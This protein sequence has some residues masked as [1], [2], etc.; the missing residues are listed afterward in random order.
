MKI[1]LYSITY[2]GVWYRGE[3]LDVFQLVHLAKEQGWDGLE[4]DAERPHAAP[5]D[6]AA[7]DRKRLRDL[8]G[9]A[10]IELCAVSPNCDLSSPVPGQR[11]AM[12]CYVRE[13]IRLAR[14]LGAPI[15]KIFAAWRGITLH[16]GMATYDDTYGY[17]QYGFWKG[18]RRHFVVESMRELCRV[19]EDS[20]VVL[21][22]QNHGPDVVNSYQDVL[23]LIEE[24][25]SPAFQACMDINIEPEAESGEHARAMAAASGKLLAHSHMNGEFA[26]RPDG[27]VELVAGGYFDGRFWGRQVAYEAYIDA[28]VA[29]GYQ[30]YIDWEFC[31]PARENGR[32]AGIEY[33]H[34]QTQMAFEYVSA[35]RAAAEE[36]MKAVGAV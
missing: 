27:S 30:G 4:L 17:E 28:L 21:A 1:G 26:R 8:A 5:M 14:D 32:P 12:I 23:S 18:D 24:I 29:A 3:A 6:L 22:M 13:C 11:E 34:R 19:A 15:C 25:G 20:G 9:G 2:R 36:K 35:L 31:H 10:G 33:I 7:D 16:D